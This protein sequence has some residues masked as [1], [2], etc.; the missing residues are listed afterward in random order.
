MTPRGTRKNALLATWTR[1]PTSRELRRHP[2]R[3]GGLNPCTTPIPARGR[4]SSTSYVDHGRHLRS[5]LQPAA[6]DDQPAVTMWLAVSLATISRPATSRSTLPG[7]QR[8]EDPRG[9]GAGAVEDSEWGTGRPEWTRIPP[10]GPPRHRMRPKPGAGWAEGGAF[11]PPPTRAIPPRQ[12]NAVSR[13]GRRSHYGR[14]QNGPD[15]VQLSG[16]ASR[17]RLPVAAVILDANMPATGGKG[18]PTDGLIE[19][20]ADEQYLFRGASA[21]AST[22][23]EQ[24][25]KQARDLFRPG[26]RRAARRQQP[27]RP[28]ARGVGGRSSRGRSFRYVI[29]HVVAVARCG[30]EATDLIRLQECRLITDTPDKRHTVR[31]HIAGLQRLRHDLRCTVEGVMCQLSFGSLIPDH[32]HGSAQA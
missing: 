13:S 6:R 14:R 12:R 11:R 1:G 10:S 2:P 9:N 22:T 18:V 28:V 16:R 20:V 7:S 5:D 17:S 24:G 32:R 8:A 3:R 15:G 26:A 25:V 23:V 31:E 30:S 29:V 27:D 4:R 19:V 21:A